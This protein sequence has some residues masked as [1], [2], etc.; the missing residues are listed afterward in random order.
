MVLHH[1][2][3]DV[4]IFIGILS[5]FVVESCCYEMAGTSGV[6]LATP[7]WGLPRNSILF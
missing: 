5:I 6:S 4:L 1:L 7:V 3:I 2:N